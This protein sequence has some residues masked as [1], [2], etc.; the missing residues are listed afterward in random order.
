MALELNLDT[1]P[2][3]TKYGVKQVEESWSLLH[4]LKKVVK[5]VVVGWWY[6]LRHRGLESEYTPER[7]VAVTRQF[8]DRFR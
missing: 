8:K 6:M 1:R 7:L 2:Q 3:E 4:K 5:G